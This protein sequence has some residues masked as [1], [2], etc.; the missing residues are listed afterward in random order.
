MNAT[1]FK[2]QGLASAAR[3][4]IGTANGRKRALAKYYREQLGK[5]PQLKDRVD[6]LQP[7]WRDW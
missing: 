2:D 1:Q 3:D 5:N 6:Q 7:G 4:V